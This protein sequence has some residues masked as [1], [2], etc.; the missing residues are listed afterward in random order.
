MSNL[1][2]KASLFTFLII[3]IAFITPMILNAQDVQ[4]VYSVVGGNT[5]TWTELASPTVFDSGTV[6]FKVQG[7]SAD[8]SGGGSGYLVFYNAY[9]G[10]GFDAVN[11]NFQFSAHFIPDNQA[12]LYTGTEQN[13]TFSTG[14]FYGFDNLFNSNATLV[15]SDVAVPEPSTYA[16]LAGTLAIGALAAAKRRKVSV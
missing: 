9:F 11:G 8:P 1:I 12:Q 6:Y 3:S 16:I 15:I 2:K 7:V 14:V 4:F 10:G 13:P 5:W